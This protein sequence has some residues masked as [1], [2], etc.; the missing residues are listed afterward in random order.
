MAY[1]Y[2]TEKL[3]SSDLNLADVFPIQ[4]DDA[5]NQ[6]NASYNLFEISQ[7]IQDR[8]DN[9]KNTEQQYIDLDSAISEII[10]KWYKSQGKQNPFV[11]VS[12]V[13]EEFDSTN[14][15]ESAIVDSGKLKSKGTPASAQRKTKEPEKVVKEVKVVEVTEPELSDSEKIE[16]LKADLERNRQ[17]YYD[18][19][20]EEEQATYLSNLEKR[21]VGAEMM[22]EDGDEY[23]VQRYN[24][25][26]DFANSYKKN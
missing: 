15:R 14:P 1:K 18:V 26:K 6:V 9:F 21:L 20:D 10:S 13:E 16:K 2:F 24:I 12:A 4:Q 5:R 3:L 7:F 11:Q 22:A 17:I 25:L 23:L 19:L 8:T